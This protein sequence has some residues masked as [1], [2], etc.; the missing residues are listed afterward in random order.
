MKSY[1]IEP[2]TRNYVK[3]NGLLS[4]VRTYSTN[5]G[6][7]YWILLQKTGI[8][9]AKTAPKKYSIKHLQQQEN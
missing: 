7:N 8:D 5:T 3:G 9:V 1:S 6:R 2:R 4:F